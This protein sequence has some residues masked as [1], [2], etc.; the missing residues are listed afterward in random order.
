MTIFLTS[1]E[2]TIDDT[3]RVQYGRNHNQVSNKGQQKLSF[4]DQQNILKSISIFD[5]ARRLKQ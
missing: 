3:N 5:N 4:L 2:D 1:H